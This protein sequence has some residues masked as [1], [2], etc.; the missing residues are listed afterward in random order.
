MEL[1]LNLCEA[2][3]CN[4]HIRKTSALIQSTQD[5]LLLQTYP[6]FFLTISALPS[7]F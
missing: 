7:L 2:V 5:C 1:D 4:Y 6:S 3:L